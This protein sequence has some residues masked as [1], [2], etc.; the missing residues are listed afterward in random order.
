LLGHDFGGWDRAGVAV[1]ATVLLVL[2]VRLASRQLSFLVMSSIM[3]ASQMAVHGILSV[4]LDRPSVAEVWTYHAHFDTS[5][6]TS[7][8]PYLLDRLAHNLLLTLAVLLVLYALELN[9]WT[10][11]R[12]AALRL[13]RPI[14]SIPP[15]FPAESPALRV[16]D[17]T[18]VPPAA[19]DPRP[20][21]RRAPPRVAAA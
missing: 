8:T 14:P 12:V 21:G 16:D 1:L 10:W 15:L 18:A 4:T 13:L 20:H 11:F 6:W 19:P 7:G 9:I 2:G 5:V 17:V 3:I